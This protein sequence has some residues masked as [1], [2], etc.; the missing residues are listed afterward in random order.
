MS[1]HSSSLSQIN[2]K[3]EAYRL[4]YDP[5]RLLSLLYSKYGDIEEDYY[6][7]NTN[8]LIY[9]FPTKLNSLFKEIK[10]SD[11]NYD[12]LKR[13]YKKKESINRIPKLSD[14]YKNYHLF[15]CR[16]MIRNRKL[17]QIMCD[18]E[19]N[20]AELFY[21]N[22]YKE[23]KEISDKLTI[24]K[25]KNKNKN[26]K[27]NSSFSF[28]F[29]SLDNVTNNKIIFDKETKKMLERTQTD[30]NNNYYNTLTLETSKSNLLSS[31]NNNNCL[32]S[33]RSTDDSFENC[34][35][36][37]VIYQNKKNKNLNNQNKSEQKSKKKKFKRKKNI[38][39]NDINSNFFRVSKIDKPKNI[40]SQSQRESHNKSNFNI[41]Q[42]VKT[43]LCMSKKINNLGRKTKI[44][45]V[46]SNF[47][48]KNK[49]ISAKKKKNSLFSLSNNK[50]ISS[51][52]NILSS[53]NNIIS[54]KKKKI[55]INKIIPKLEEFNLNRLLTNNKSVVNFIAPGSTKKNK[56]YIFSNNNIINSTAVNSNNNSNI[57]TNLN[58]N[59]IHPNIIK[60]L[61][62][63]NENNYRKFSKLTEYLNQTK[64]KEIKDIKNNFIQKKI[65]HKKSSI[66]IGCGDNKN[67]IFNINKNLSNNN[68]VTK[69]KITINK[70]IKI[71]IANVNNN[72]NISNNSKIHSQKGRHIK[73]KAFDYYT[74]NQS[75]KQKDNNSS[76]NIDDFNTIFNK[77]KKIIYKINTDYNNLKNNKIS[78]RKI[79]NITNNKASIV[80]IPIFSP[81]TKKIYNKMPFTQT[82]SKEKNGH[83]INLIVKIFNPNSKNSNY[84]YIKENNNNN[85]PFHKKNN[86]SML[87]TEDIANNNFISKF[88]IIKP[89]KIYKYIYHSNNNINNNNAI[90]KNISTPISPSN[91]LYNCNILSSNNIN[92]LTHCQNS[93]KN[94]NKIYKKTSINKNSKIID[95]KKVNTILLN[96]NNARKN[97]DYYSNIYLTTSNINKSNNWNE[98]KIISRNKKKTSKQ[99]NSKNSK[100]N[101]NIT[102]N[103]KITHKSNSKNKKNKVNN[104][105]ITNLS[106]FNN[107]NND[108]CQKSLKNNIINNHENI[109]ISIGDKNINIK[110]SILHI[111]KIYIKNNNLN[112]IG[113]NN[114]NNK[115]EKFQNDNNCCLK[116]KKPKD[117]KVDD[118][119]LKKKENINKKKGNS[120]IKKT[121]NENSPKIINVHRNTN[122]TSKNNND[123]KIKYKKPNLD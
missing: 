21:K 98:N 51:R 16:P 55:I 37:L 43:T 84:E 90:I 123:L 115:I 53:I 92:K 10:Y 86:Y 17:C 104:T 95:H 108:I 97:K 56:T 83:K 117:I 44:N 122:L 33:K 106:I 28:S 91:H 62:F 5:T 25:N 61:K 105:V 60:N 85:S 20:K 2:T 38:I 6:L 100:A 71:T 82:A 75:I 64:N 40:M 103:L 77:Q 120:N 11:L 35:H 63:D 13:I 58:N 68:R 114:K 12:Y 88:P 39:I 66:S 102:K 18:Y 81:F 99:N 70:N 41:N 111:N 87:T 76:K 8:Q 67:I 29:S 113:I 110:D 26:N 23:S 73:N 34:I 47:N 116:Y 72:D 48:Q 27:K 94:N 45:R 78:S 79:E 74:I 19:D 59:N 101:Y 3:F 119:I 52:T 118:S 9:N 57:F 54:N 89:N 42:K 96:S 1:S 22:N 14:Y 49:L 112:N 46:N 109:N 93:T 7:L 32:I 36:A 65:I 121:K 24:N 69:K 107:L 80:K 30:Y 31:N 15:F 50:Y 4:I